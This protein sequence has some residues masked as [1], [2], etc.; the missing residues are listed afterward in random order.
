MMKGSLNYLTGGCLALLLAGLPVVSSAQLAEKVYAADYHIQPEKERE[1]SVE[2][3]G[4]PFFKNNEYAGE[5][6]KGYSLPGMW[7]QP[8]AVYYPL[9]NMKLELGVHMLFYHGAVKY[10]SMAYLDI[11][12][13]QGGQYQ[14]GTHILPWFRAQAALS[15][16]VD[17]VL[18][19]IYGAA[20]HR[21]IDPLYSPEL[22]LTADPETGL[23]V[24][25]DTKAV[26]LDAWLNWQS[27]IFRGDTHQ[28]AFT[29]GLSSRVKLN[30]PEAKWHFYLPVQGVAQHRGGEID[31]LFTNS[32]QTLMNGAAGAGV[33]WNVNY[34]A[35]KR[36]NLEAD[37]AG[38]YQQAGHLW[39]LDSGY[40]N[41]INLTADINDFRVKASYWE[42]DDFISMFGVPFYGAVSTTEKGG[43]FE[44]PKMVYLGA[45]YARTLGKGFA[46][47]VDVDV[48]YRLADR[49][50]DAQ[51][52][53]QPVGS[54]TSFSCG[55]YL[56]VN[57]SFL[58]KKF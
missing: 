15:D 8:K 46:L 12:Y 48:Y 36:I 44:A 32:V 49:L 56:R 26:N 25:V 27:F 28:E 7:L 51:T 19:N 4:L 54:S 43:V 24:L 6:M 21:L 40:G 33:V 52:G 16:H 3:D 41:Y 11:P 53:W 55:V 30:D 23:Q 22:N 37:V 34:G 58:L 2:I 13:W 39:P 29:V 42:C 17:I 5:V 45:E 31:T 18:G 1:L 14:Y 9:R 38:Y 10:P 50:Y 57:P 47:G 35:L 20:N